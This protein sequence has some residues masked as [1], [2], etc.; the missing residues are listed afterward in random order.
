[1]QIKYKL[2]AAISIFAIAGTFYYLSFYSPRSRADSLEIIGGTL[3]I[4]QK[5]VQPNSA[6][7]LRLDIMMNT[8]TSLTQSLITL[9]YPQDL[10]E[11]VISDNGFM[12][13]KC[14]QKAA[15]QESDPL[16]LDQKKG[17]TS[18]MKKSDEAIQPGNYCFGTFTFRLTDPQ[19]PTTSGLAD[20]T[21]FIIDVSETGSYGSTSSG[22]R[23]IFT[24]QNKFAQ[25]QVDPVPCMP[26]MA[27]LVPLSGE[28]DEV[29]E[30]QLPRPAAETISAEG[31]EL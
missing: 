16:I 9:S 27:P 1:M 28:C 10:Y 12:S 30:S 23:V 13:K 11:P 5:K 21:K 24:T 15:F 31:E 6:G 7:I 22:Q 4:R 18:I 26:L 17:T 8:G 20:D 2:F 19:L 14:A 29:T 25:S 3:S